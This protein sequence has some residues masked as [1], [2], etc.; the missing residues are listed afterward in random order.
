MEELKILRKQKGLTM[1]QL[2][3]IIGVAEST[4]SLY[5]NGKR[6][7]DNTTL[8]SLADFFNVSTDFLLG[9]NE[10]E[11]FKS[12]SSIKIPVLG[13]GAA[14]IPIDA[15][16]EIIDYEEI[17]PDMAKRGKLIGLQIKGSSME[18]QICNGDI[19]IIKC[20]DYIDDNHI[21]I[22]MVN[23]SEATCKKIKFSSA[24]I[25]LISLNP[26]FEP[27]FY[28]NEEIENLP[29]RIFGEVIELRRKF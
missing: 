10:I 25:T 7:P 4:I 21:G 1:K 24:G 2:G 5:E 29:V 20:Q 18:P 12:K 8:K 27:I 11:N 9:R 23:G 28:S 6:Q 17:P 26:A 15:I 13:R 16:E 3:E 22:V 14:G 19:V